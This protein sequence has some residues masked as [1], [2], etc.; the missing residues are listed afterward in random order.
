M[1][2]AGLYFR[3]ALV[4][5]LSRG[6]PHRGLTGAERAVQATD[7]RADRTFR[8]HY[9]R[10]PPATSRAGASSEPFRPGV[11]FPV[12]AGYPGG[13]VRTEVEHAVTV[14]PDRSVFAHRPSRCRSDGEQGD[15]RNLV[16]RS[17]DAP[18]CQH[19]LHMVVCASCRAS[20]EAVAVK[21]SV[22][23]CRSMFAVRIVL[24]AAPRAV[25]LRISFRGYSAGKQRRRVAPKRAVIVS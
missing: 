20:P 6:V 24:T 4:A 10:G 18:R 21:P 23:G 11:D 13:R 1:M 12:H 15:P 7:Q 3:P 17:T 5:S 16:A 2:Q 8:R 14:W 19:E 25:T 22:C 9:R